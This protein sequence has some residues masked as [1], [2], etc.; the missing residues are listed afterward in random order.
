MFKRLLYA[1]I[2]FIIIAVSAMFFWDARAF[3][4]LTVNNSNAGGDITVLV[5]GKA[6]AGSEAGK[7]NNAREL[8][9][10]IVLVKYTALDNTVQLI[11]IPR[12]LYGNFGGETFKVNEV[13][14]KNKIQ[15]LLDKLPEITGISTDKF[16][17]VDLGIIKHAVDALGGLDI[18]LPE[19]VTDSVS[20]YTVPAGPHHFNGDDVVWLV[21][22]RFSNEGDFFREKNQH[23]V[24]QELAKKFADLNFTERMRLFF[25]LA[26]DINSLQTNV[27]WGS[28]F[29]KTSALGSLKFKSV[30]L[31]FTTGLFTA[32]NMP[33]GI[34]VQY[35]L[36]PKAGIDNYKDIKDFIALSLQSFH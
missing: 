14:V 5:L 12:D 30:V 35:V 36:I 3:T 27:S 6:G 24:I 13:L 23:L 19:A 17:V 7:W 16:I 1:T 10:S 8:T 11:S 31:D 33:Y 18:N 29:P 34:G 9:D 22:N 15:A 4:I 21:R 20:G 25:T 28:F 26:P 32:S 2:L